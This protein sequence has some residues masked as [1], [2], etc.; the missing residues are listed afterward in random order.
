MHSAGTALSKAATKAGII[1]RKIVTQS[2]EQR[3]IRIINRH[4]V[5]MSVDIERH[6]LGHGSLLPMEPIVPCFAAFHP[7][8]AHADIDLSSRQ[9]L[10][11]A[12]AS[13]CPK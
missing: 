8:R 13:L 1:K 4:N 12:S 9:S 2:I 5:A 7:C 11:Q 3:H 6:L 10:G